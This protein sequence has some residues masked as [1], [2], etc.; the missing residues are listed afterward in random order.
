[1]QIAWVNVWTVPSP[2]L[3]PWASSVTIHPLAGHIAGLAAVRTTTGA[4]ASATRASASTAIA[5]PTATATAATAAKATAATTA[6]G[7]AVNAGAHRVGLAG[8]AGAP[9]RRHAVAAMGA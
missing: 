5:A 2:A 4:A 7:H 3:R 9:A 1:M 8:W 6:L